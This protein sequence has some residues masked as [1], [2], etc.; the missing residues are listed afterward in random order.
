[1]FTTSGVSARGRAYWGAYAASKFALEGLMQ[2]LA[3]ETDTLT[4]HPRRTASIPGRCARRCAP[5]RIRARTRL[6]VP[7]PVA[8]D[9]DL[10]LPARA[11]R[12]AA[13]P[14]AA[15][16]PSSPTPRPRGRAGRAMPDI[17]TQRVE[18]RALELARATAR[19]VARQ[20]HRA[21]A[22]Q[23]RA[24]DLEA[25]PSRTAR[26]S[27][28]CGSVRSAATRN[29]ALVAPP[30]S[31]STAENV[32]ASRL[33]RRPTRASPASPR[34]AAAATRARGTR[35]GLECAWRVTPETNAP[36][37]ARISRPS[38][39]KPSALTGSQRPPR[40]AGRRVSTPARSSPAWRRSISPP[41][42]W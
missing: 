24:A 6:R 22:H 36:S 33:R 11:R 13:S 12:A 8:G 28:P 29:H 42:L 23:H 30:S 1:M 9:A 26:G 17:A 20:R 5:G 40:S 3:D 35:P 19:Q 27:R 32:D 14:A 4:Q 39:P 10:P 18:F 25:R 31:R 2:V 37:L 16:T 15:S 41:G 21:P 38:S 7:L 34:P